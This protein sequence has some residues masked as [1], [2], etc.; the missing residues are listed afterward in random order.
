[1]SPQ[2]FT[3]ID[4]HI[5][6]ARAWIGDDVGALNSLRRYI[7][8]N[9]QDTWGYL[10]LAVIHA[11]AGRSDDA[12]RAVAEAVQR[13]PDIDVEQVK[14]SNRYRDPERLDRLIA[15]LNAAGLD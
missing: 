8:A 11:F 15:V 5:G 9:P 14:R 10:M 12:R 1:L 13:K 6:H 7:A 3:W 4:F 2:T